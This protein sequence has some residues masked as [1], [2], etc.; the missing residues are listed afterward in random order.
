MLE[1]DVV[2]PEDALSRLLEVGAPVVTAVYPQWVNERLC[3]NVQTRMPAS[4]GM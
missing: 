1:G 3:S 4:C 2:P